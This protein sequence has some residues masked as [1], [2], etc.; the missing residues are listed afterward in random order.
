MTKHSPGAIAVFHSTDDVLRYAVGR[1]QAAVELYTQ[2]AERCTKPI[3]RLTFLEFAAEE[4]SHKTR[5]E[6][7]LAMGRPLIPTGK[8]VESLGISRHLPDVKPS[9]DLGM[10]E[11]LQLAMSEEKKAFIVYWKLAEATTGQPSL[12]QAFLGLAQEEARHKLRFEIEYERMAF[13]KE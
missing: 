7:F 6:Q 9:T 1:E 12:H 2:L 3:M 13:E 8:P 5:L 11:A 4:Q 10:R